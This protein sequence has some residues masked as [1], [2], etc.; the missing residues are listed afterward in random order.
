M[1][2]FD[3]THESEELLKLL[4]AVYCGRRS[5]GKGRT[6]SNGFGSSQD[7]HREYLSNM[8]S[9][10]VFEL[11]AELKRAGCIT[12]F[13]A[14]DEICCIQLTSDALV[15]GEQTFKRNTQ[16]LLSWVSSIKGILPF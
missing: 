2:E 3:I 5:E 15:Y 13:A 9:D 7:I 16:E 1:I 4:Y 12:G 8:S 14:G 11:C 6:A 10:D